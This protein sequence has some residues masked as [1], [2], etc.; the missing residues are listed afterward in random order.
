MDDEGGVDG[1]VNA[2]EADG[3]G[4]WHP[5]CALI[6]EEGQAVGAG[7][8]PQVAFLRVVRWVLA[9]LYK[10]VIL[11]AEGLNAPFFFTNIPGVGDAV[12]GGEI[13]LVSGESER[14]HDQKRPPTVK[15]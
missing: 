12:S 6:D 2:V 11:T 14:S 13:E 8:P 4:G 10:E 3:W 5:S 7:I 1:G 9:N 15:R